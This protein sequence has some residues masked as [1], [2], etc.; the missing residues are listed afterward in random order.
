MSNFV[1]Q[2]IESGGSIHPIIIPAELTKGTGTFNPSIYNDNGQLFV[3]VRHCQV[4]IYHSEKGIFEHPWGP[5]VYLHPENDVTL[6]TTNYFCHL[7]SDLNVT[8]I[9]AIDFSKFD[10]SPKW[11]FIGLEDCRVFRWKGKLYLCGVRRDTTTNGV[12]RMELS[13][14]EIYGD[15]VKEVSRFRIPAPGKDDSYC[16]KNWMPIL[17]EP[18]TFVKWSNPTEIA[19]VDLT[20][21]TCSSYVSN[22]TLPLECDLRGGSQVL[23]WKDGYIAIVHETY[24]YKSEAGRKN[25]MYRHRFIYWDKDWNLRKM[26]KKFSFGESNIEFAAGMCYHNDDM[27][28]S[29]GIQDNAAYIL[30]CPLN[31]IE[32]ALNG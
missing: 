22:Q 27:L 11:E 14:I 12:G 28:I 1:K 16:E 17:D 6:T 20:H 26:S 7:D 19:S 9:N 31:I 21:K 5:L 3:N 25:G 8:R 13:E 29:F 24:L 15:S 4:T 23:K 10:E 32:E 18:F 30:R 2:V